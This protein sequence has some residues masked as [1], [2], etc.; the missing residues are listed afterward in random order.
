MPRH[1]CC[2]AGDGIRLEDGRIVAVEAAPERL[3][4]ITCA[5]ERALARIAW[6]L[7]N[8]HLATEIAERVIH[9]R[10]DHVIADMVRGLGAAV[11]IVDAP[12]TPKAAP[13]A[14]AP[15]TATAMVIMAMTATI[16]ATTITTTALD[17]DAGRP[18]DD[19]IPA[20]RREAVTS[21]NGVE[22]WREDRSPARDMTMPLDRGS[23]KA[24][25]RRGRSSP[26][27]ARLMTWLSPAF[28]VGGFSYS[29][30]LEWVVETGKVRDAATLGDWIEDILVHGAGR[31]DAIF[32]AEAW[33]A[34][35]AA[36]PLRWQ[37]WPSWPQPS[38][39]RPSAGW[40]RWRRAQ[41]S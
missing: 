9:I 41:P 8:R 11:R 18:K 21:G 28:P 32:L 12:S 1:R 36:M 14:T 30:G 10:D 6:H 25:A 31:T 7:G 34:V 3:L 23:T 33:R 20:Q 5:D 39:R 24:R 17:R 40:R 35:S 19:V 26:T 15:C 38:R 27:L 4:E 37:R 2:A 13:T 22:A 29:H 16:M